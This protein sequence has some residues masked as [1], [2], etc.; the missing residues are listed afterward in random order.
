MRPI[1]MIQESAGPEGCL[2]TTDT[3]AKSINV[4]AVQEIGHR[5]S[6]LNSDCQL[7][8]IY[9]NPARPTT[10]KTQNRTLESSRKDFQVCFVD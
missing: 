10:K 9:I 4:A 2:R 3:P 6:S 7:L 1:S 8:K 5:Y